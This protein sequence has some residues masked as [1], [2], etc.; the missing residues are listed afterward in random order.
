M[1]DFEDRR[2]R[3]DRQPRRKQADAF[4]VV[5]DHYLVALDP[6]F[7]VTLAD[8]ILEHGSDNAALLAFAHRLQ[9]LSDE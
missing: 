6:D 9:K 5:D 7:C 4:F 2:P 3:D 8:H 1:A